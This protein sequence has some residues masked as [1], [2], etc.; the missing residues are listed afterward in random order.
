MG[1]GIGAKNATVPIYSAEMAPAAIRGALV[2]FW[3][4]WVVIGK[5]LLNLFFLVA[6]RCRLNFAATYHA[7]PHYRPVFLTKIMTKEF[8]SASART[9]SSRMWEILLGDLN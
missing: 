2:M 6:C 8:F 4:L 7:Y 3:Q 5:S 9:S 1:I